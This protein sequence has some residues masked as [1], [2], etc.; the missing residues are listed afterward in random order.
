AVSCGAR[1][2]SNLSQQYLDKRFRLQARN[3]MP[4]VESERRPLGVGVQA[5]IE[6]E[7]RASFPSMRSDER[8]SWNIAPASAEIDCLEKRPDWMRA[9]S[10]VEMGRRR[11]SQP[12]GR[13]AGD[14]GVTEVR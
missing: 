7:K 14:E 2:P 12:I 5:A 9:A 3:I 1:W 11:A 13:D 10:R 6:V 4:T 8:L